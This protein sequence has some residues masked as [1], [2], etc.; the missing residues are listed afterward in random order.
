M[1]S[2]KPVSLIGAIAIILPT[3]DHLATFLAIITTPM[4]AAHFGSGAVPAAIFFLGLGV[5]QLIWMGVL[6]RSNNPTL[7]VVGT[8]G[9]VFSILIYFISVAGVMLLGVPPQPL[10]A[11][12]VIAKV[13]EGVF[14]AASLCVL[15]GRH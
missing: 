7:L 15:R 14:V 5:F 12:G 13:L 8:V 4:V 11:Q 2:I 6:M 9:N 10:F 1:A 3:I